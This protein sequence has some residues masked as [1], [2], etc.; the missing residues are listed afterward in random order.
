MCS[1]WVPEVNFANPVFLE[2]IE[3]LEN[4]PPARWRLV[5][6]LCRRKKVG[7]CIQCHR[8]NCYTAFHV[9]CALFAGLHLEM[10]QRGTDNGPRG[11]FIPGHSSGN[12]RKTAYC[13]LHA[14][15]PG[16]NNKSLK[17]DDTTIDPGSDDGGNDSDACEQ[18]DEG[19]KLLAGDDEGDDDYEPGSVG[20][21][22]MDAVTKSRSLMTRIVTS[23]MKHI[24]GVL[25]YPTI[26]QER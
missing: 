1:A 22:K 12:V 15:K 20:K 19:R 9:T 3:G 17:R 7:A 8:P 11:I 23:K 2:P 10:T 21:S 16:R 6:F 18:I 4:I 26:S 25:S 13:D 24:V 14:P 5:C